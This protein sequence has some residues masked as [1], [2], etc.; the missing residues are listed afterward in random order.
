MGWSGSPS[1]EANGF[2]LSVSGAIANQPGIFYFGPNQ[3]QTSFGNG[4]RCVGG[5]VTRLP[6]V[7]WDGAGGAELA[8]DLWDD[9]A[10][11]DRIAIGETWG[12]QFWYRNPTSPGASTFNLSD[13]LEVSFCP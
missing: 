3:I 12:F 10:P 7:F 9:Q 4:W 8:L 13:G 6:V 5:G 11:G 1:F 2:S